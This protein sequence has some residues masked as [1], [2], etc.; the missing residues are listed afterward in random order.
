MAPKNRLV[1][2]LILLCF[3]CTLPAFATTRNAA[4][5]SSTDVQSAIS[6]A[7]SGDTVVLPATCSATWS[8]PVTISGKSI[9]LLGQTSCTGTPAS[10]CTD[11]T[12]IT[13]ATSGDTGALAVTGLTASNFVRVSGISWVSQTGTSD[14]IVQFTGASAQQTRQVGFRFDHNHVTVTTGRGMGVFQIWGLIDHN[15]YTRNGSLQELETEGSSI[16]SDGGFTP[17]TFPLAFG[18]NNAIVIEDNTFIDSTGKDSGEDVIDCYTGVQLTI[19]HNQFSNSHFGCH[20]TDSG[21]NRSAFS[22][23]AYANTFTNNTSSTY[24]AMTLRGGTALYWGN[25]FNGSNSSWNGVSP[26]TYRACIGP[27]STWGAC[28]GTNYSLGSTN[29][30]S[31]ASRV[32]TA[33]TGAAS[34]TNVMFCSGARDQVCTSDSTCSAIGAGTCSTYFDGQGPSGYACRDQPG[35]THNQVLAPMYAWLNTGANVTIDPGS[36]SQATWVAAN[37]D[38]YNYTASFDGTSGVGVGLLSARPSTCTTTTEKGGGVAYWATDTNTL[39][40]CSSTNT[41]TPYYTPY[42]YPDPLQNGTVVIVQPPTAL[43]EVVN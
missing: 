24:R 33:S 11:S 2:P 7:S 18:T 36:C 12:V 4:S 17:W 32:A 43:N 10:S 19:R 9:T 40:Q 15:I 14:G 25:T 21:N 39:Y 38:F 13:N 22:V 26:M 31:Q 8:S 1:F 41:W 37:R 3:A 6:S 30:A 35:R 28:N 23:E 34:S 20:G 27:E 16:G 29:F 5:C 42:V